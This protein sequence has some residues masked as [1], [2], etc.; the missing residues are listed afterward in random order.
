MDSSTKG[1]I[2][3]L[4]DS[5]AST[6]STDT[7]IILG[8]G[9]SVDSV[10]RRVFD[11]GLV[12]AL[13]DAERICPA[14]VSLIH[15]PWVVGSLR[16]SGFRS[17]LYLSSIPFEAAGRPVVV[18]PYQPLSQESSELLMTRLFDEDELVIEELMLLTAL[19]IALLVAKLRGR[20][21]T[22]YMLG[23]DFDPDAGFS[24][25]TNSGFEPELDEDRGRGIEAQ[26]H[27][28]RNALNSLRDSE[29]DVIHV[30]SL[31]FSRLSTTAL[32]LR[33]SPHPLHSGEGR[34]D[35]QPVLI[36]A[37]VTTN[38]YGDR[39]RL[40]RIVREASSAGA[41]LVK[42]QKR[43]VE[44]F[45]TRKQLSAHYESPFGSTFGDYRRALE[46]DHDDFEFID[47]LCS[48]LGIGWFASILDQ[49]SFA[50]LIDLNPAMIKLPSTISEHTSYLSFVAEN[51]EGPLVLSTGMTDTAYEE[52]VLAT[53]VRQSTLYLLHANSGYPTPQHHCNIGV[54]RHYSE[55]AQRIPNL[56]PGY[57][58][59]DAGWMASAL[60]V[61]AGAGMVEKHV[62]LGNT[63]WAH[64]D[65]VAVDLTTSAFREY[66]QN[67]R[68][69]QV[70]V[71]SP[72]KRVTP[73]EHHKYHVPR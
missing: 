45:Y 9:P 7:V 59:H 44:S 27:F 4:I 31:E 60:A 70:I 12:I 21:Q 51:Y 16:D 13:N 11:E 47:G 6:Y 2:S 72:V 1:S 37:E 67:V 65:A 48:E 53:F 15:E 61:A 39:Q 28:L 55:L 22:V 29:L 8:K 46:L 68:R 26:G 5:I 34:P 23:F 32:N 24:R 17:K 50:F 20:R 42:F 30:G 52:W 38:H 64:F 58:S 49:P 40:E 3:S 73:S 35:E 41:D 54:V 33:F 62:K 18:L 36:V 10:D 56:V 57:S 43:D 63:D 66:V 71:G 25:A 69:A 14:D 19:K